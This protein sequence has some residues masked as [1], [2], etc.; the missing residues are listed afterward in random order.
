MANE[1]EFGTTAVDEVGSVRCKKCGFETH[2]TNA[3]HGECDEDVIPNASVNYVRTYKYGDKSCVKCRSES[4]THESSSYEFTSS[5]H[6]FYDQNKIEFAEKV[7][8]IFEHAKTFSKVHNTLYTIFF[9]DVD[10]KLYSLNDE[11]EFNN[12]INDMYIRM[13]KFNGECI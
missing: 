9:T 12:M 8:Y 6:V 11:S 7:R 2:Y 3:Y 13:R 10:Y 4:S 1:H 5:S